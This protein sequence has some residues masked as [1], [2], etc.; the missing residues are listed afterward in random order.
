MRCNINNEGFTTSTTISSNTLFHFTKNKENII[1]ILKK[2]FK[3]HLCLE[4]LNFVLSDIPNEESSEKLEHAIPM[5]CFCDIPLSQSKNIMKT[6]GDYGIGLSK[7][8]GKKNN[9]S[10]VLYAYQESAIVSAIEQMWVKLFNEGNFANELFDD[11][12]WI[13]CFVKEYEGKLWDKEK[14]K[15]SNKNTRFYDEREWRFVPNLKYFMAYCLH[16][17]EFL[18]ESLCDK[19]N[20]EL[21]ITVLN[22]RASDV[23][24]IIVSSN[25][26]IMDIISEIKQMDRYNEHEKCLLFTKLISVNQIEEDF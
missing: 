17:R 9:I 1:S 11:I 4:N 26:E 3:P 8:W 23:K 25:V 16:K 7:D 20:R 6:Y 15:Y 12:F 2:G 10:P 19:K 14:R 21:E 22:F 13:Y 5:V 24:Y 18:E